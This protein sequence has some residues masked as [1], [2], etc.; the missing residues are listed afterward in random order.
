VAL[1]FDGDRV[2]SIH[3]FLFARYAMESIT[4]LVVDRP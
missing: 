1:D 2:S 4:V 3:D